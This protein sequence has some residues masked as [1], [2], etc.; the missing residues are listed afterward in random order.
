MPGLRQD[1]KYGV[2]MLFK[3][4]SG[5]VLRLQAP[6]LSEEELAECLSRF[7]GDA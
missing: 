2:R 3:K 5:E 1:L 6:F 7:G 4:P